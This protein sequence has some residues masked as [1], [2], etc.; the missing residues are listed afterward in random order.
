MEDD[1]G[2]WRMPGV[3]HVNIVP[4]YNSRMIEWSIGL[5]SVDM[6]TGTFST[7]K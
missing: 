1:R 4:S 6:A 5:T 2:G 3:D 7:R